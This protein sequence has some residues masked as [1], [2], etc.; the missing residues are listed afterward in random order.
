MK[1]LNYRTSKHLLLV[2][3]LV[4]LAGTVLAQNSISQNGVDTLTLNQRFV[5][6]MGKSTDYQQYKVIKKTEI[7]DFWV[8]TTDT[9][10]T[11]TNKIENLNSQI[12]QLN[13]KIDTLESRLSSTIS[14]LE[15]SNSMNDEIGFF[16]SNIRKSTYHALV[17]GIIILLA[18]LAIIIYVMYMNSNTVTVRVKKESE[19]LRK[20]FDE[21]RDKARETQ[22]RLKRELQTAVN[23]LDEMKRGGGIRR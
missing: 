16:G 8:R 1:S 17:W 21:H 20:E 3:C 5:K 13:I 2:S 10:N 19:K 22:V 11:K 14:A 18:I 9:L 12:S 6:M 7:E 4:L 23:S 15:E